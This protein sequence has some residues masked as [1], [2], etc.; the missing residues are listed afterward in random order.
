MFLQLNRVVLIA[1]AVLCG[2]SA[3]ASRSPVNVRENLQSQ[4]EMQNTIGLGN[5]PDYVN[6][7]TNCPDPGPACGGDCVGNEYNDFTDCQA[8]E[9]VCQGYW[10]SFCY[11]YAYYQ[12]GDTTSQCFNDEYNGCTAAHANDCDLDCEQY[13]DQQR[14]QCQP[15]ASDEFQNLDG[16]VFPK[17]VVLKDTSSYTSI[18]QK[19]AFCFEKRPCSTYCTLK[20]NPAVWSCEQ[21]GGFTPQGPPY[22]VPDGTGNVQGQCP[23]GGG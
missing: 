2:V 6:T 4:V 20:G 15:S 9:T 11:L 13:T 21:H 16:P 8:E 18:D 5:C 7:P 22:K 12:C 23:P 3:F 14:R 19:D 1:S 17:I 10:V